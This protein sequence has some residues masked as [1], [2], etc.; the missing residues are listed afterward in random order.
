MPQL[1]VPG[2][3]AASHLGGRRPIDLGD[4]GGSATRDEALD[5]R[6]CRHE[7]MGE[8]WVRRFANNHQQRDAMAHDCGE[9]VWFETN[10][11]IVR[12]RYPP[13]LANHFQPGFIFRVMLKMI[14]MPFDRQPSLLENFRE[15]LS[16]ITVS[17]KD[18]AQA[19]ARS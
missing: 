17:E 15:L 10:A 19:A 8:L 14:T 6:E 7:C 12:E 11:A 1:H 5:V 13:A 4:V 18:K 9:L 2:R 16:E 3:M